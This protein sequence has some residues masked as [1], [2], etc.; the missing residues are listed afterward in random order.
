MKIKYRK[1]QSHWFSFFCCGSQFCELAIDSRKRVE[2]RKAFDYGASGN[3]PGF[4]W[5]ENLNCHYCHAS[6]IINKELIASLFRL[7]GVEALL[8]FFK[9]EGFEIVSSE[10][11]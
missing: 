9:K 8:E 7:G 2:V 10:K 4:L 5:P 11:V 3:T 6:L 1:I